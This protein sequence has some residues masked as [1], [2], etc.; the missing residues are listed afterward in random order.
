MPANGRRDLIRRLKVK[1]MLLVPFRYLVFIGAGVVMNS[2]RA[3]CYHSAWTEVIK[4][5]GNPHLDK[6][7]LS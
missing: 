1:G 5:T 4:D 3:L 7:V 6:A 2:R